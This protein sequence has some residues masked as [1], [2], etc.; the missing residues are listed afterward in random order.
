MDIK[1]YIIRKSNELDIDMVGFTDCKPLLNIREYLMERKRKDRETEFEEEDIRRRIDPKVIFPECKAII[2]I[3][4][5]YNNEFSMGP[6]K[7]PWG[8][9]S[10]S[11]W[12]LDYHIILRKKMDKLIDEIQ[13]KKKF[14]Y[15][16]FVDT[17]PLVDR[18][19]AKNA[20]IGYYGK[21]CSVINPK[22]GSFIFIGY[23]LTD[24]DMK[25]DSTILKEDCG[26]C[27][28]CLKA[29]PTGALESS[30]RLN[31]KRCISYLTQTKERIPYDLR[32]HMGNSIYGCD[33]CQKVCPKNKG[34]SMGNHEEFIPTENK[35]YIDIGDILSISNRE[36]NTRYS[37]M[38]GSWRGRNIWRRNGIIALGNTKDKIYLPMLKPFLKDPSPMI[39]EY[40]AWAILNIDYKHGMVWIRDILEYEGDKIV[41]LEIERLIDYFNTRNIQG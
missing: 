21:N 28:L 17:G 40:T 26:D 4:M 1:Q 8:K 14:N 31:P 19:L 37:S 25:I 27:V 34:I 16:S 29:C 13:R 2:V 15:K 36:F 23:I 18:E 20:G 11:S 39:R 22:Y 32:R 30:Y 5:S 10:K 35:S 24:L 41:K 38:A 7:L 9:L 6:K 12:G 33:I 3:S